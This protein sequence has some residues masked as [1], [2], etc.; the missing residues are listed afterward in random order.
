MWKIPTYQSQ[1]IVDPTGCGDT[2][3]AGYVAARLKGFS[4]HK[5]AHIGAAA[6]SHKLEYAGPLTATFDELTKQISNKTDTVE[7]D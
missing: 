4:P 3:L 5:S 7:S 6:A 1:N 2:Y